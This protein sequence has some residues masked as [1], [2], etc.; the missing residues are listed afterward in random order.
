MLFEFRNVLACL[1]NYEEAID[2]FKKALMLDKKSVEAL[3]GLGNIMYMQDN[4]IDAVK[5]YNQAEVRLI[6]YFDAEHS[7]NET[8]G[9][10]TIR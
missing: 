7:Y 4:I 2:A 9:G 8:K 5:Y 3:F 10:A 1:E 6:R